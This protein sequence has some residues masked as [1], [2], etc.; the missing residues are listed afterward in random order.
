MFQQSP[1]I[2]VSEIDNT[3][4]A[5]GIAT[6]EAAIV[7]N[8]RWGP[9]QERTAVSS[10]PELRN[11]FSTPNKANAVDFFNAANYLTYATSLTLVR[12]I[13]DAANSANSAGDSNTTIKNR[14]DYDT[15]T[16][17][18]VTQG[19]WVAKYP[20]ALGNS[21]KV[22]VFGFAV[23]EATTEANFDAW[24]LS[25]QFDGPVG[26]SSWASTN[27][28]SNDEVHVAVIDEDGLFTGTPGTVL[29]VWPFLSQASG[30]KLD[31]GATN[32]WKN[33]INDKSSYIWFAADDTTNFP[34]TGSEAE[35]GTDFIIT[36]AAGVVATSLTAGADS[37]SLTATEYARGFEL[38]ADSLTSTPGI[39]IGPDL[40]VGSETTVANALIAIAEG[41]QDC[42]VTLSPGADDDSITKIKEW[43]D[44]LTAS[45][46][47]IRDSG[48]MYQYDKYNDQ[49]IEVPCS[50]A[51]A[52]IMAE[53]DRSYGAWYSPAGSK[54]GQYRNVT[55]LKINP[56]QAER[57][58]LYKAGINPVVTF[59]GQGTILYGDKTG[60]NRPSAF[61]RINVRRLFILVEKSIAN[62]SRS[63]LFEFNDE[64]TRAQF[65]ATVE[66]LLRTIRG[67]RG[68]EDYL[69]VCDDSNNTAD[70]IDR[71]E[72]VGDIYIKPARSINYIQL[73]FIATRSSVNFSTITGG[74]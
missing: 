39:L 33:V 5:P 22:E 61:D 63:T 23:D 69:V 48:R 41:R 21:L 25:S 32:Y 12:E 6:S 16:F 58:T 60:L 17:T 27:G 52:G 71:N 4:S 44:S 53:T 62:A 46:F 15:K 36:P 9:V 43:G 56:N 47:A 66:P 68:I 57:D 8:F 1:G 54:R 70:V 30:A 35:N 64:F 34:E 40:P 74:R 14:D 24:S 45:S 3:A 42:V 55:K 18:L 20:G 73:N 49:L 51:T 7:G 72:F 11:I 29:E 59:P 13:T 50:G 37:G 26:T 67:R 10:E 28:A 38:F 2:N 19:N 31:N 65:V